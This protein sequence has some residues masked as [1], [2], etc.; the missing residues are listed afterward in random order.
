[1]GTVGYRVLTA[2]NPYEALS[3]VEA[4]RI[5]VVLLDFRFPGLPDGEWLA[6]QIRA[7]RPDVKLVMLSGFPDVPESAK[8]SV[9]AFVVKGAEPM[10]LRATLDRLLGSS[11]ERP[12][13][14]NVLDENFKLR[15]KAKE[16]LD[17]ARHSRNKDIA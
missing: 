3:I 15:N 10:E 8:G 5:D 17:A 16:A 4:E 11:G 12:P 2:S 1:L 14:A 9:D 13:I 7:K 6:N